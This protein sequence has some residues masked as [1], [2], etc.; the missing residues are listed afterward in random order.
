[1]RAPRLPRPM[2]SSRGQQQRLAGRRDEAAAVYDY[3]ALLLVEDIAPPEGYRDI[4]VFNAAL[5]ARIAAEPAVL[6]SP[7]SKATR[8]GTQTGELALHDDP[9]LR[10]FEGVLRQAVATARSRWPAGHPVAARAARPSGLRAWATTLRAGGQQTPHLHPTAWLSGVYYV[11][12]PDAV[13]N[14][15][16]GAGALEFGAPPERH[17]FNGEPLLATVTPKPGRLVLF[18]SCFYHRTLPFD[19][20]QPRISM[21]FDA[22]PLACEV[23]A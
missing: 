16:G 23:D 7:A 5:A 1:M 4:P 20:P 6:E 2:H 17:A 12:V 21:A 15:D 8:G 3:P 10:A 22:V 11:A 18:P 9:A 13:A 14:P 19:A